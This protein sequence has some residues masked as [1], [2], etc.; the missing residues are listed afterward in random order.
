MAA[1]PIDAAPGML[2]SSKVAKSPLP[3][4]HGPALAVRFIDRLEVPG[5]RSP[6]LLVVPLP[7]LISYEPLR[8]RSGSP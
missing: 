8:V 7:S 2:A 3:F 1:T 4:H 6:W 5:C